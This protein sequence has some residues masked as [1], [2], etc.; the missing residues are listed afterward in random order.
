MSGQGGAHSTITTRAS[1]DPDAASLIEK[2]RKD[3]ARPPQ[4][5]QMLKN[6]LIYYAT[7]YGNNPDKW[8]EL[9]RC[10]INNLPSVTSQ[11]FNVLK[12]LDKAH[13]YLQ[14][15]TTQL[16]LRDFEH[17]MLQSFLEEAIGNVA[18]LQ[19]KA[20]KAQQEMTELQAEL[21]RR[22]ARC[23]DL[24]AELRGMVAGGEETCSRARCKELEREKEALVKQLKELKS[25]SFPQPF[26]PPPVRAVAEGDN[27]AGPSGIQ[28]VDQ[29]RSAFRPTR[30]FPEEPTGNAQTRAQ[31]ATQPPGG[32]AGPSH[33]DQGRHE[34]N[35][36]SRMGATVQIRHSSRSFSSDDEPDQPQTQGQEPP[37]D[38]DSV[39]KGQSKGVLITRF[40]GRIGLDKLECLGAKTTLQRE[41]NDEIIN[42]HGRM[43]QEWS[44]R[45]R[46][47]SVHNPVTWIAST[48]FMTQV[49]EG[50][51]VGRW[52]TETAL[53][54]G[55]TLGYTSVLGECDLVLLPVHRNTHWT[56]V[57][58]DLGKRHLLYLNSI[59]QL[60]GGE[61][62]LERVVQW[63]EA[64][65][66]EKGLLSVRPSLANVRRWKRCHT[67]VDLMKALQFE[68]PQQDT[69]DDCGVFAIMYLAYMCAG[70]L[71]DFSQQ[72]METVRRN[73][74]VF[75]KD[76]SLPLDPSTWIQAQH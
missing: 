72:H 36:L 50:K 73:L 12:E 11:A 40:G 56:V 7:S 33:A 51:Y 68:V 3:V 28:Q 67:A 71:F 47:E 45:Q 62:I 27:V 1:V 26:T 9:A 44:V 6:L 30:L 15:T 76:G 8:A 57:C 5:V 43:I 75:I 31:P 22:K 66:K 48:F 69:F 38:W 19:A 23:A 32:A 34:R 41:L 21:R 55:P 13:N 70:R 53:G 35:S 61:D 37:W 58:V 65:V 63:M 29:A 59:V 14:M 10:V 49:L 18:E 4:A 46:R 20:V 39:M 25:R 24:E 52:T 17:K 42:L 54:K 64:E 74:L 60:Q 16:E 2:L